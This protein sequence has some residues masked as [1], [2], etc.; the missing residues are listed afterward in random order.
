MA[1]VPPSGDHGQVKTSALDSVARYAKPFVIVMGF[2][3]SLLTENFTSEPDQIL[4]L[5]AVTIDQGK[6]FHARFYGSQS[7][8]IAVVGDFDRAADYPALYLAT[9]TLGGGPSGRLFRVLRDKLG[10]TYGAYAGLS[11]DAKSERALL[12]TQVIYAPQNAGK[13]EEGLNGELAK[14]AQLTKEDLDHARGELLQQRFQSRANDGE[15]GAG[16]GRRLQ[17]AGDAEVASHLLEPRAW[18]FSTS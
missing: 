1:R 11:A 12:T 15:V 14:F 2:V 13:V 17:D 4:A 10:L 9:N 3:S 7:A 5:K 6:A 8:Q 16:Q 18:D